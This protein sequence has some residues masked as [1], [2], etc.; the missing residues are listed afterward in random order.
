M[1]ELPTTAT[2]WR[3]SADFWRARSNSFELALRQA[4]SEEDLDIMR[5]IIMAAL[6]ASRKSFG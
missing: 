5:S 2:Q 4:A 6:E 3:D 1:Y